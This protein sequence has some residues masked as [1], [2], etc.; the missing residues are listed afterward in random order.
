MEFL[1]IL[2]LVLEYV[3]I[4]FFR[5]MF[6]NFALF[7]VSKIILL[8]NNFVSRILVAEESVSVLHNNLFPPTTIR[9][10]HCSFF[11]DR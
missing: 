7:F 3:K 4:Y 5:S 2:D 11:K 6:K 1:Y 8:N 10:R 9:I